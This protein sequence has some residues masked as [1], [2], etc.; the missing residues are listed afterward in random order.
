M[1]V[2]DV[3]IFERTRSVIFYVSGS[4]MRETPT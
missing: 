1:I 3:P 4:A 2:V